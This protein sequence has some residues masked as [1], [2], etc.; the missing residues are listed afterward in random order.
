MR[1]NMFAIAAAQSANVNVLPSLHMP[2]QP[3][4]ARPSMRYSKSVPF[5]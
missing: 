2:V 5:S 3:G 1:L 4:I